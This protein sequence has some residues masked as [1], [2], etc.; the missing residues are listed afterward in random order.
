[1]GVDSHMETQTYYIVVGSKVRQA[2]GRIVGKVLEV[3][4]PF[5]IVEQ[6]RWFW[7][8]EDARQFMSQRAEIRQKTQRTKA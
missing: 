4:T 5:G 1:M 3:D 7:T 6:S 2:H 8:E